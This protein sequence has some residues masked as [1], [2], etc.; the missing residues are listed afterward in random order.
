MDEPFGALDPITR[1]ELHEEFLRV[2]STLHRAV[3]LV[4]HD[5][6]EAFALADR[7]AV[8]HDGHII[9]LGTPAAVDQSTDPR[10][11]GLV[12]GR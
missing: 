3:I 11:A 7:V 2:Q 5:I 10:V 9:A 12:G 4:T 6:A 8:L 1:A